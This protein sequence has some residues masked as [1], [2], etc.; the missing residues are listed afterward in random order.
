[1]KNIKQLL[2]LEA[3][4]PYIWQARYGVEKESQR[5]TA[6]GKLAQTNHPNKFGNRAY[7]PYI[8]TDFAE[9]QLELVTPVADSPQELM[10]WLAAIHDVAYRS[11]PKEEMMWPLS[12]PPVLPRKDE[13]IMIA[14]LDTFEDVLYRRYLAKTYGKRKQMVSGIHFNFEFGA[15]FLQNLFAAQEQYD[16]FTDFKT[17]IYLK[18]TRNY[19]RYRWFLTYLFG[20]SPTSNEYYFVEDSAPQEP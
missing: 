18:V 16:D 7:H 20:A 10:N 6:D 9:T 5:I 14:K 12:M 19:L 15:D 13:D 1:M 11:L 4:Q 2:Q 8:Q 3:L 17:A